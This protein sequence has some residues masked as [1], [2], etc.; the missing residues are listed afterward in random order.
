MKAH[1][2]ITLFSLLSATLYASAQ[3]PAYNRELF[4]TLA[5]EATNVISFQEFNLGTAQGTGF[6]GPFTELGFVVF[7]T[8]MN[9]SQEVIEGS[10]VGQP[11]NNV[12]TTLAANLN[13]TIADITFGRGVT[14]VGFDLKNT[15]NAS[16]TGGGSQ[17]YF[18]TVTSCSTNLGTFPIVSPPGGT[19]FQ[20]FGITSSNLIT[21][22][23]FTSV[24]GTPNL[25]IVLDNFA[26]SS[27]APLPPPIPLVQQTSSGTMVLSWTNNCAFALQSAADVKGPYSEVPGASSPYTNTL[28]GSAR[29]FRLISR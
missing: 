24:A 14:A 9:F 16:T 22:I 20:F 10:N 29:F 28:S 6:V 26:V 1:V 11:G 12:Y 27:E 4:Q 25:D 8:N 23:S 2:K 5:P 19:T 15:A 7:H 18:A 3:T 13:L 17:T 21:E